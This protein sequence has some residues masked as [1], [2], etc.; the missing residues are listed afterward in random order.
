MSQVTGMAEYVNLLLRRQGTGRSHQNKT[1]KHFPVLTITSCSCESD[2]KVLY[3]SSRTGCPILEFWLME[4]F[5]NSSGCLPYLQPSNTCQLHT[6]A[7]RVNTLCGTEQVSSGQSSLCVKH[8]MLLNN[9][10]GLPVLAKLAPYNRDDDIFA[11]GI[12]FFCTT[13]NFPLW[14][15]ER[16]LSTSTGRSQ[17]RTAVLYLCYLYKKVSLPTAYIFYQRQCTA[18]Q[19]IYQSFQWFLHLFCCAVAW[20]FPQRWSQSKKNTFVFSILPLWDTKSSPEKWIESNQHFF[21]G[22][23]SLIW[24]DYFRLG[25]SAKVSLL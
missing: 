19:N 21:P 17:I 16:F 8:L 12:F 7:N 4:M 6:P 5:L 2:Y 14:C 25:L 20:H 23:S 13:S 3:C 22:W 24:K 15:Q 9:R 18:Q 1:V 11:F 10:V